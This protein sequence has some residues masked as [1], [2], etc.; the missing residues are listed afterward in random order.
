MMART[1]GKTLGR[2]ATGI[3]V[4]RANGQPITFRFAVV[5]EVLVKVLLFALLPGVAH[6]IDALWPLGDEENRA[7]H[8]FIVSTRTIRD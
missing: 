3:R 1:N 4:V 8:D 7:I 6:L 2:M 5:R